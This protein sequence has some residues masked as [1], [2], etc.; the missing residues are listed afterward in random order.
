MVFDDARQA[1]FYPCPCGDKFMIS[2]VRLHLFFWPFDHA[3]IIHS[4]FH[5]LA[6]VL[7]VGGLAAGKT[8]RYFGRRG[9]GK[10]S[11]MQP[12]H[13]RNL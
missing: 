3:F 10:V 9:G 13:P 6:V 4:L 2:M 12:H 11:F 5:L 8:G 1:Y 7:D